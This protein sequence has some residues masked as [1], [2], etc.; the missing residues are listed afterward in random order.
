MVLNII[1]GGILYEKNKYYE[2]HKS[3]MNTQIIINLFLVCL[4]IL[5]EVI[6][7]IKRKEKW[8]L[9]IPTITWMI[10]SL[11]FYSL[12]PLIKNNMFVNEWSQALRTH[13]YTTMLSLGLYRYLHYR[14][15][16]KKRGEK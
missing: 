10:H 15:P 2:I 16:K 13:G 9:S 12:K 5:L 1:N 7:A 3:N 8:L 14:E 11:I 4:V 6:S